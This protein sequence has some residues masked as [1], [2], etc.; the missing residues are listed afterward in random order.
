MNAG[1]YAALWCKRDFSF[2]E[3]ASHPE[4]L[5]EQA[6]ELW[7]K[8]IVGFEI[9]LEN[10]STLV[11]LAM[12]RRGESSRQ[13]HRLFTFSSN[14]RPRPDRLAARSGQSARSLP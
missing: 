13:I 9:T 1:R 7:L 3:G 12:T 8:L 4:K 14:A 6:A 5:V 10:G 11:L 2:V